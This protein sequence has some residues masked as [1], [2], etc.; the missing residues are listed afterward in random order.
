MEE[1]VKANASYAGEI[2]VGMINTMV[3]QKYIEPIFSS[4]FRKIS[5]N[6]AFF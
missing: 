4:F 5:E 1:A 6:D 3:V 2:K